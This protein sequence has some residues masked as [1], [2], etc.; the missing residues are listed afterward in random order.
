M[1][2]HRLPL[3]AGDEVHAR[4][5]AACARS[6]GGLPGRLELGQL[7]SKVSDH[8]RERRRRVS[9]GRAVTLDLLLAELAPV[10]RER[11]LDLSVGARTAAGE[12]LERRVATLVPREGHEFEA[13]LIE[14]LFALDARTLDVGV[15]HE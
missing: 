2:V 4:D 6:G 3:L 15:E 8:F 12:P 5:E 13:E 9:A 11:S 7:R 10:G 1:P 14:P